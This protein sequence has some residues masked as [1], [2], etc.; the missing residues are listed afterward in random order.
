MIAQAIDRASNN[1]EQVA[2][3]FSS[4]FVLP[5]SKVALP[6]TAADVADQNN[7]LVKPIAISKRTGKDR[8]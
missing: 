2:Q 1:E 7:I 8:T 6:P 3:D 4:L 5:M